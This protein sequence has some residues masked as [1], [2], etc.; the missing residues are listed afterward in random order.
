MPMDR[1]NNV[2]TH[3][4]LWSQK[5]L[6]ESEETYLVNTNGVLLNESRFFVEDK[7]K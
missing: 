7:L 4:A 1:I 5:G 6:G 2:L 3:H